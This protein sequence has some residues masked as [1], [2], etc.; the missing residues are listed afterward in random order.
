MSKSPFYEWHMFIE[1]M[2][3]HNIHFKD[4]YIHICMFEMFTRS[5]KEKKGGG[6][7]GVHKQGLGSQKIQPSL[8]PLHSLRAMHSPAILRELLAV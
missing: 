2:Y 3:I 6:G 8:S 4:A 7:K 5:E 1:N